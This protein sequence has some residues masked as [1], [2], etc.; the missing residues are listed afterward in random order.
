MLQGL[1]GVVDTLQELWISYNIIE[2][3]NGVEKL[4]NLKVLWMSNNKVKDWAE[5]EKL[6][7]PRQCAR[8]YPFPP[9]AARVPWGPAPQSRAHARRGVA[10]TSPLHARTPVDR[11]VCTGHARSRRAHRTAVQL[12]ANVATCATF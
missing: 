7:R 9:L 8:D 5:I 11:S 12:G 3:L 6:V 2:K 1:D 10:P 4:K